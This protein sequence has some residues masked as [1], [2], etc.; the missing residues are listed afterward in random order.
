MF[1]EKKYAA[2]E[3]TANASWRDAAQGV[4]GTYGHDTGRACATSRLELDQAERNCQRSARDFRKLRSRSWRGFPYR[5]RVLAKPT[6][7]LGPVACAAETQ[8]RNRAEEG[9]LRL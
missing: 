5:S 1:R 6:E 4:S 9:K 2:K 3:K 8:I 7:K